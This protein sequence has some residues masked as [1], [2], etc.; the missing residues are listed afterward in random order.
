MPASVI[1]RSFA[2]GELAPVLHARADLAKYTT[3]LRTCRN[4]LVRREG[5]VSNR[6]GTRYVNATKDATAAHEL[7]R[8]ISKTVGGS[9]LIEA[10]TGYFRFYHN[11]GL[12]TI[13]GA[14]GYSGGTQYFIGDVVSDGGVNYYCIAQPVIGTAPSDTGFWYAMPD[15]ILEIPT[16]Y[17]PNLAG[18]LTI[19]TNQSG[20]TITITDREGGQRPRELIYQALTQ[21][22]FRDV[23]TASQVIPPGAG[24]GTYGGTAGSLTYHYQ[25]T[26]IDAVTGEESPASTT[27]DVAA[28]A[29]EGPTAVNP[30]VLTWTAEPTAGSYMIYCD[31]AGNGI[32]GYIGSTPLLTYKHTTEI[33]DYALTPPEPRIL[34]D[35]PNDYPECACVHQQRRYFGNTNHTPDGVWGS[36]VG[37]PSNYSISTPL[38]DDDAVTFKIAGNNQ[39]AVRWLCTM[40]AGLILL[41]D[42]GEWTATGDQ[43]GGIRA[44][45][46][47]LDEN[48]Y[49]GVHPTTPPASIG[50][51]LVYVQRHGNVVRELRFDQQVEGLAGRDLTV[52]ATHLFAGRVIVDLDYQQTPDSI[53]WCVN[54]DGRL[55]GLTYIPEQ[56]VWGWHRHDTAAS[57]R[58]EHVCVVPEADRD[59][60]YVIVQRTINGST[61][62]YIEKLEDRV[63]S[64]WNTDVFFVDAGLSYS[65]SPTNHVS[66]L[67]HLEGQVVAVVGDGA[68]V[69]NGDPTAAM[70]T[71][72]GG[73]ITLPASYSDIHVGLAIRY[74][75]LEPLDLD[76]SGEAIRDKWKRTG[77]V[78][79]L[80]ESSTRGFLI[81]PDAAH[82]TRYTPAAYEPSTAAVTAGLEQNIASS[83]TQSGRFLLRHDDPLPLT[84]LAFV[85]SVEMGG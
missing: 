53:V 59:V 2:A 54:S 15:D 67:D 24:S 50:N 23:S 39:H 35:A 66:G 84:V 3:G 17:G 57:G 25:I 60:V 56:D 30:I 4:F 13:T 14:A 48:T 47:Q 32:F 37:Y 19:K 77:S 58:F 34:F 80:V 45:S 8:Y 75:E 18:K 85:P 33:P 38:Q 79:I 74:P 21:W 6:P 69:S 10:G 52:Y 63:I 9:V 40:K 31:P 27:I 41:T 1:Q 28:V 68:V 46:I 73:A 72:S 71:V 70:F 51:G 11:G 22:V 49:V 82:L 81:G 16:S 78:T 12:V 76:V 29:D 43:G 64:T 7:F 20:N 62:R 65:G 61:V 5:G 26:S 36:K 44:N 55:E 83:F 42:G